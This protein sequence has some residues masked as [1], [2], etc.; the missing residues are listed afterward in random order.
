MTGGKIAVR[1]LH[2]M[3]LSAQVSLAERPVDPGV[4]GIL[5]RTPRRGATAI[6]KGRARRYDVA[7]YVPRIG[8]LL[9]RESIAPAGGAETQILLLARA[10][11]GRGVKVCLTVF[12]LPGIAIPHSVAGVAVC[13]RPSYRA[14]QRLGRLRE[15][16]SIRGAI[17]KADAEVVVTRME[18]PEV[19]IAGVFSKLFGRRF[20][21][22]SASLSDFV[23]DK[24]RRLAP[25]VDLS[26]LS[27]KGSDWKLFQLGI[28]LADAV[29][30]Q[31]EEQARLYKARPAGRPCLSGASQSR[32]PSAKA[33]QRRSS[34]SDELPSPSG[35]RRLSSWLVVSP[36]Q[37][38]G[39]S[40]SLQAIAPTT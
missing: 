32:H 30:V 12:D 19:G 22:S 15:V 14:R 27:R 31:T 28:R 20:V 35:L 2:A 34:G 1:A 6:R 16:I 25:E 29:V 23:P 4:P 7:F 10:L 5:A 26:R 18:S 21:Y 9:V 39:W 24:Q 17:A 11:A 36:K 38:S 8:P 40:R 33:S 3:P 37:G 13:V